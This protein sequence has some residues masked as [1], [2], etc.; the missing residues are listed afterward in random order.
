MT[1]GS[2]GESKLQVV[3]PQAIEDP[4]MGLVSQ[5]QEQPVAPLFGGQKILVNAPQYHWHV[6][7]VV[8]ADEEPGSILLP[9]P[10]GCVNLVTEQKSEDWSYGTGLAE[11]WICLE[12]NA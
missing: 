1:N 8:G 7:G 3:T 2:N 9:W 4:K 10:R 6:Q 5:M 12:W 11:Q